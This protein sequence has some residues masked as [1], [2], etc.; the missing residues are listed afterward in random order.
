MALVLEK[1]LEIWNPAMVDVCVRGRC[2]PK[3]RIRPEVLGHVLMH[4]H[5]QIYV[6][7]SVAPDQY[8]SGH[9]LVRWHV[10]VWVSNF[11]VRWIESDVFPGVGESG[12]GE[13]VAKAF[14][15]LQRRNQQRSL[16]HRSIDSSRLKKRNQRAAEPESHAQGDCNNYPTTKEITALWLLRARANVLNGA[17]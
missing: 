10:T 5:L 12:G 9:A 13:A 6:H 16:I 8:I 4:Q 11:V 15:T 1:A 7:R 3:L 14:R 2:L 17:V